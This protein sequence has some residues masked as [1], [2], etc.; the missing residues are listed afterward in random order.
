MDWSTDD[1]QIRQALEDRWEWLEHLALGTA[2][3]KRSAWRDLGDAGAAEDRVRN[4][5]TGRYPIELLQ[6]AHDACADAEI[7]GKAWFVITGTALLI[8]NQG[9]PFTA[10]RIESLTRIGSSEKGR[11]KVRHHLIGYKGIGFTA[12]FEITDRP[13]IISRNVSFAFDRQEA[14]RRVTG[15]LG[16]ADKTEQVAARY[17]PLPLEAHSWKNDADVVGRLLDA[18]AVTVIRLPLRRGWT[19]DRV[20]QDLRASLTAEM[21]LFTPA[22]SQFEVSGHGEAY[23]WA[24]TPGRT[25][26]KARL[27]HLKGSG[28]DS[29]AW[30]MRVGAVALRP[31]E[32]EALRDE[33]WKSV[34][35]LN[36]AVA[37]PWATGPITEP[38]A[39]P[40]FAY[41]PT[42]DRLGR[43]V[44]I[45]GDFYLDEARQRIA[46]DG[47]QGVV[48]DRVAEGAAKLFAQL[49]EGVAEQGNKLLSCLAPVGEPDGYGHRL[50]TNL[51]EE[52]KRA[53][54][55]RPADGSRKK[56]P[57]AVRRIGSGLS[58][59]RERKFAQ[60][61]SGRSDLVRPGDD[62]GRAV[63]LLDRLECSTAD[64][65]DLASRVE[66][67]IAGMEYGSALSLLEAWIQGLD[68]AYPVLEV[69]KQRTVVQDQAGRWCRPADVIRRDAATPPLPTILDRPELSVP[70][71]TMARQFIERLGVDTLNGKA[72]LD[73]LVE[74]LSESEELSAGQHTEVLDF[75]WRLW[76]SEPGTLRSHSDLGVLR[77]PTKQAGGRGK[78][79]WIRADSAYFAAVWMGKSALEPLYAPFR[80]SEFVFPDHLEGSKRD[81][82]AFFRAIGIADRPRMLPITSGLKKYW[83]WQKLSDVSAAQA[84]PD[85]HPYTQRDVDGSVMDRLDELLARIEEHPTFAHAFVRGLL[86]LEQPHGPDA[87]VICTHSSHRGT[88]RGNRAK[89]YQ[90]WRLEE[91][92]WVPVANHPAGKPTAR[93]REAWTDILRTADHFLVAHARLRDSKG[94]ELVHA[95]S[96]AREAVETAL[97]LLHEA[98][99][100]LTV[101]N[102]TARETAEW[103]MRR[104]ERAVQRKSDSGSAPPLLALTPAGVAWSTCPAIPD[105]PGMPALPDIS[106]LPP[107][108]WSGVRKAYGL[109]LASELVRDDVKIG[110]RLTVAP[111]LSEQNKAELTALLLRLG[112]APTIA[113]RLAV[114]REQAATSLVVTWHSKKGGDQAVT[115]QRPFHLKVIRDR[116][117][118]ILRATLF[119][120]D[121]LEPDVVGLGRVIASYLDVLDHEHTVAL[122]L[123][124]R[125]HL[126][127]Q[128]GVSEHDVG[129]ALE[130]L[131]RKR[132]PKT[133]DIAASVDDA[134][135]TSADAEASEIS[136]EEMEPLDDASVQE[137]FAE[138]PPSENREEAASIPA[139][140]PDTSRA[141][142]PLVDLENV[143]FGQPR[144]PEPPNRRTP[145]N[146][147]TEP[148]TPQQPPVSG[149]VPDEAPTSPNPVT[150][151]LAMKIADRYGRTVFKAVKVID[152]HTAN[153]G[154]DLEF[155]LPDGATIP[156]EVKGTAGSAPF[157]ITRNEW[158]AAREHADFLLI[159]VLN[160]AT[161]DRA[162]L[163]IFRR[164]GERL[165]EQH[166]AVT[167]WVV[168]DWPA[169][170]PE[171]IPIVLD[172]S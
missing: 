13:Q 136:N 101:E 28:G 112:V 164:L 123:T 143:D 66:P 137:S 142:T 132:I 31:N 150:E 71:S 73:L 97:R 82:E 84:C 148:R 63:E 102:Q 146:R 17:F 118:R 103:L 58:V 48:S 104:L 80:R 130:L 96:P 114:L 154:W 65:K 90:R 111:L 152:V 115:E 23:G 156:V 5:H 110:R 50:A 139:P 126:M 141:P 25:V 18:G 81:Q 12:A 43:G 70:T 157:V 121:D 40:V 64:V 54:I 92:A 119:W 88:R 151:D 32:A 72:A 67:A 37:L 27:W 2:A 116:A 155:H 95:E 134:S 98:H 169:L 34:R 74:R 20:L 79:T 145:A 131:R 38:T 46:G 39:Q 140:V 1:A 109:P 11:R 128:Q 16:R 30:L 122:Y 33:L 77:V 8:A 107:G 21:L 68:W 3:T 57:S 52:L 149:P 117:N 55:V 89:G 159:H 29:R 15:K 133:E 62:V 171:E 19:N 78:L 165:S 125:G 167:S 153:K 49:A 166:L 75:T 105:S 26:G 113:G 94:L 60:L 172:T 161:P 76:N 10:E 170:E 135:V 44:L 158:R 163:R 47:P 147:L 108:R 100:E 6:N 106:I 86:L 14:L 4:S 99:P 51:D 53:R 91:S 129:E 124:S 168:K 127:Q 45:H 61:L 160:L 144:V 59:E 24:R 162:V 7:V 83:D 56:P 85:G 42:A 36:V 9:I 35:K 69:L 22:I 93:P 41:F 138:T 87:R 120:S